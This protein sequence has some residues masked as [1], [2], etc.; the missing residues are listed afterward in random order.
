MAGLRILPFGNPLALEGLQQEFSSE[1]LQTARVLVRRGD[2]QLQLNPLLVGEGV[3]GL[4]LRHTKD[5]APFDIVN[6]NGSLSTGIPPS[7]TCIHDFYTKSFSGEKKWVFVACSD[8]DLAVL[9][10]LGLPCTPAAGLAA[11]NGRHLRDLFEDPSVFTD[12][13]NQKSTI[14]IV[15]ENCRLV[16]VEWN[17]AELKNE[18][19]E[20]ATSVVNRLLKAEDAFGFDTS[21]R[22]TIWRPTVREFSR[23]CSAAELQDKA[24][25][26]HLIWQSAS[27]SMRSARQM[28]E[29]AA[30][31]DPMDY[32]AARNEL[33]GTIAQARK[34]GFQSPDVVKKLEALNRSF[35]RSVVDLMVRAALSTTDAVDRALLLAASELMQQWHLSSPVVRSTQDCASGRFPSPDEALSS[36]ELKERLCVVDGLVKIHRE[37]TRNK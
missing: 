3:Q 31:R 19:P 28:M 25:A 35:G 12:P 24:I 32:S 20:L 29:D 18:Q 14:P 17:I 7:L 1:Q 9:R 13:P 8:N 21:H 16:L 2:N 33:L 11:M 15:S 6:Q 27:C 4:F 34:L 36:D 30:S 22:L 10:M 23:I 26:Q 37:L 5:D